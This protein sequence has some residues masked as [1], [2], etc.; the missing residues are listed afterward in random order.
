MS[1][2]QFDF[3]MLARAVSAHNGELFIHSGGV[4][5]ITVQRFPAAIPMSIAARFVADDSAM[6]EKHTLSAAVR[7][8][9][10]VQPRF[11]S[12]SLP[13]D[14]ERPPDAPP[15]QLVHLVVA[16]T[17]LIPITEA[18]PYHFDL[19]LDGERVQER[20][21]VLTLHVRQS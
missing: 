16:L 3:A 2:L 6:G 20:G 1:G 11:E 4:R 12:P 18:G 13:F 5:S 14:V 17:V 9:H 19:L 10:D 8:P 7:G 15:D 21:D